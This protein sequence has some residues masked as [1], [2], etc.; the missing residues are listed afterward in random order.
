MRGS[1]T[2]LGMSIPKLIA[3]AFVV[4]TLFAWPGIG[5]LCVSAIFN[6]DI[7]IVQTYVLLLAALFVLFNLI[8]DVLVVLLDPLRRKTGE[9]L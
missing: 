7:P 8:A 9:G 3:G 4:E 6:R 5:R 2:A 1:V